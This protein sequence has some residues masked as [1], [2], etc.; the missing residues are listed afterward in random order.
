MIEISK[1]CSEDAH[2][3]RIKLFRKKN[4]DTWEGMRQRITTVFA[5]IPSYTNDLGHLCNGPGLSFMTTF[6]RDKNPVENS[7]KIAQR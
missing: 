7:G 5:L 4:R 1:K 6:Y 2:H 3:G